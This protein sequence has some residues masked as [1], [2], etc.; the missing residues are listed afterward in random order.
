[1][2]AYLIIS[3]CFRRQIY[4]LFLNIETFGSFFGIYMRDHI[5][6][7]LNKR[8]ILTKRLSSTGRY[9]EYSRHVCIYHTITGIPNF[10]TRSIVFRQMPEDPLSHYKCHNVSGLIHYVYLDFLICHSCDKTSIRKDIFDNEI[11]F[12]IEFTSS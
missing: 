9:P 1:M 11:P 10:T 6:P 3:K 2:F 12:Q 7:E 5:L 8:A 4:D